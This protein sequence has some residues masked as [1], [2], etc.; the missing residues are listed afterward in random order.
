MYDQ[1]YDLHFILK[2]LWFDVKDTNKASQSVYNLSLVG[3]TNNKKIREN[4][5]DF[6]SK[7]MSLNQLRK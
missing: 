7:R 2:T 1:E 3:L 4:Y 6:T 5:Y